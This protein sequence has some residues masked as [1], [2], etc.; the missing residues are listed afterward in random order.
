MN[1]FEESVESLQHIMI[2]IWNKT[3]AFYLYCVFIDLIDSFFDWFKEM[4]IIIYPQC[5]IRES[6][7]FES[8]YL[9]C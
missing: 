6:G 1:G 2:I 4:S 7:V 5:S 9:I 8:A 3:G